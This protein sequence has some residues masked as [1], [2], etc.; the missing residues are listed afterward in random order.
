[1]RK[2]RRRREGGLSEEYWE[3]SEVEKEE[4]V[5]PLGASSHG[6]FLLGVVWSLL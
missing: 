4:I 1:M 3:N 5:F 6:V 2:K